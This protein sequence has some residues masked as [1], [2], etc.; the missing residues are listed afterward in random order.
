MGYLR[1]AG[2]SSWDVDFRIRQQDPWG[3]LL[4]SSFS[5]SYDHNSRADGVVIRRQLKLSL[6]TTTLSYW[7]FGIHHGQILPSYS[8]EDLFR[9][10]RAWIREEPAGYRGGAW[11]STDSRKRLS[12]RFG[13]GYGWKDNGYGGNRYDIGTTVRASQRLS[14]SLNITQH[15][16][17]TPQQWVGLV[18][19]D[20]G[21]HRIYGMARQLTDEITL[22]LSYAFSPDLSFQTYFQPFRAKVDYSD[23]V[24]LMSPMTRDYNAFGYS[25]DSSFIMDNTIGTFV[26]RWEYL[27]GSIIYLVYNMNDRNYFSATDDGWSPT[28]SNTLFIKL[29]YWFQA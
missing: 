11:L 5:I 17:K 10:S 14:A 22:R 19:N 2:V 20:A 16:R 3:R 8:D 29:N 1:R 18:S 28:K 21:D 23:Y 12:L 7:N 15:L 25:G 27:P 4:K 6:S 24:E 26:T 13:L 9:D